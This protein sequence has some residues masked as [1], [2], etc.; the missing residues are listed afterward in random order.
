MSIVEFPNKG[1]NQEV[2]IG[3]EHQSTLLLDFDSCF[4]GVKKLDDGHYKLDVIWND[5]LEENIFH[6]WH[7]PG[8][9]LGYS[10]S[11]SWRTDRRREFWSLKKPIW[12]LIC[13][14]KSRLLH[15]DWHGDPEKLSV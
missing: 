6:F 15:Q 12:K 10:F 5:D 13:K 8:I 1:T 4:I 14:Y 7:E 2:R 3:I 9:K 11:G